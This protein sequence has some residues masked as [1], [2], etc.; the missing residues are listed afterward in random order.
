M[1]T[2]FLFALFACGNAFATEGNCYLGNYEQAFTANFE[3]AV[4]AKV[5][6]GL[7]SRKGITVNPASV[8][9]G[10]TVVSIQDDDVTK[11]IV[12]EGTLTTASGT[13]MNV[14]FTGTEDFAGH[15][16]AEHIE[17]FRTVLKS[18]GFDHE[19]NPINGQC[20]MVYWGTKLTVEITNARSGVLIDDV[21]L[22]LT[23]RI[24]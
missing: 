19:G 6:A 11:Y 3:K 9:I 16:H 20:S 21:P 12:L 13:P 4:T 23:Y 5:V 2:F 22:D 17:E 8:S 1:K 24:Y 15:N 14:N 10:A 7:K 18:N